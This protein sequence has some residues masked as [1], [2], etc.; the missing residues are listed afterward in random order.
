MN[1]KGKKSSSPSAN[2]SS[3]QG[4]NQL[5][6]FAQNV[7]DN[8]P[9]PQNKPNPAL[10]VTMGQ[11]KGGD[12]HMTPSSDSQDNKKTG[13]KDSSPSAPGTKA[14]KMKDQ[15]QAHETLDIAKNVP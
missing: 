5:S 12:A 1:T 8:P 14:E 11:S 13:A 9:P 6:T 7:Q 2:A 4:P 3:N 15:H 10:S